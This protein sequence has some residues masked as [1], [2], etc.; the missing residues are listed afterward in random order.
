MQC[1]RSYYHQYIAKDTVRTTSEAA[2]YGSEM[3]EFIDGAV[4]G[5]KEFSERYEF[6]RPIV[7]SVKNASGKVV[8]E[9]GL[10]F[11]SDWTPTTWEDRSS[12]LKGKSDLTIF[13][14]TEPKVMIKDWKFAGKV[15]PHKYKL[16]MDMFALLHFKK[17]PEI[18]TISTGLVWLKTLGPESRSIYHRENLGEL[19]TE[20]V[21]KIERIEEAV[22]TENFKTVRSGLCN[23]Y[24]SAQ[25]CPN[26][27]PLRKK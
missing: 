25:N 16:E 20:I 15:E 9:Y 10:A 3:H 13:H 1:P 27:K 14:P 18:E 21:S 11:K 24:C 19:E 8:T 7:D 23:G 22:E 26:W 6:L 2:A 17:H 5:T 4:K 12:W